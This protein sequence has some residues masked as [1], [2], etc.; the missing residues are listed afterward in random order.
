MLYGERV[1]IFWVC[2]GGEIGEVGSDEIFGEGSRE[3]E[4]EAA[5][6]GE[7]QVVCGE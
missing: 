3:E 4:L 2:G 1:T 6:V 7:R 5:L